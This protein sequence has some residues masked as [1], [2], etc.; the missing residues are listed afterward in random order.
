MAALDIS[1]CLKREMSPMEPMLLLEMI[2]SISVEMQI[3][4]TEKDVETILKR[5]N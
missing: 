3:Y 1:P 4:C 5:K 2:S